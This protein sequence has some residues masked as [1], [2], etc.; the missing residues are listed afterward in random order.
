LHGSPNRLLDT[1]NRSAGGLPQALRG[2]VAPAPPAT[3]PVFLLTIE[4]AAE[5]ASLQQ[6]LGVDPELQTFTRRISTSTWPMSKACPKP[7]PRP[8]TNRRNAPS[9]R[10]TAW[11]G[12]R[13][14]S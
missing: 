4:D 2:P 8:P 7:I 12:G 11:L 5:H 1:V 13:R 9:T 3:C 10:C 6:A 14:R